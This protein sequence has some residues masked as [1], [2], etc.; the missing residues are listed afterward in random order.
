MA[1][2][3]QIISLDVNDPKGF[4]WGFVASGEGWSWLELIAWANFLWDEDGRLFNWGAKYAK[5]LA[6]I[7]PIR[8]IWLETE[9]NEATSN[10]AI[11]V[12]EHK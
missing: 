10:C 3:K 9:K 4:Q 5:N 11:T 2:H 8:L 7:F 12:S 1:C 6:V